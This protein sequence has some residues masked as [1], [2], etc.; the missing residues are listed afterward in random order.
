MWKVG[1]KMPFVFAEDKF[2]LL[3]GAKHLPEIEIEKNTQSNW[4]HM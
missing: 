3:K 1:E 4:S 2:T